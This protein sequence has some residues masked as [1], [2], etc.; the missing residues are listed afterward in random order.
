M[1]FKIRNQKIALSDPPAPVNSGST[2]GTD[3]PGYGPPVGWS[4]WSG[5][6]NDFNRSGYSSGG[7][8]GGWN[9][10]GGGWDRGR[11]REVNPFEDEANAEEAVDEQENTGINFDAYED[12]LV[13]TSG[14]NVA[15]PVN[16]FAEI[17]LG[18]ELNQNIRRCKYVKPTPVQRHTIPISLSGRDLMACAQTGFGK[19]ATFC[20]PIIS[21]IMKS[22]FAL[23][24]SGTS[25]TCSFPTCSYS[26]SNKGAFN[27]SGFLV[28]DHIHK[29]HEEARKFAY[30]T[31]VKVVVAYGGAP[32]NQ[33]VDEVLYFQM[34]FE[35]STPP[36]SWA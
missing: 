33:Q 13:E 17:D 12:I 4:R 2:S 11:E 32:I 22:Q 25:W 36:S 26:I 3:R 30:Q 27:S 16:T 29:I 6:R 35:P 10:R 1:F 19:T 20:F 34:K 21:G 23:R 15:P 9:S 5:P 31:G 8:G 28:L 7:R 18:E 24:A 14:D